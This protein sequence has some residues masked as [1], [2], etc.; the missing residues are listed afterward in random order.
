MKNIYPDFFK[1]V[2]KQKQL[3]EPC[4]FDIED[5]PSPDEVI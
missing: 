1:V 2:G 3:T 4:F 5:K